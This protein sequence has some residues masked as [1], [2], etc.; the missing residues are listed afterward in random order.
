MNIVYLVDT[1]ESKKKIHKFLMT[2]KFR[3][4]P[5]YVIVIEHVWTHS[6]VGFTH[7]TYIYFR[8]NY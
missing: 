3:N 5:F 2:I 4:K 1:E 8:Q 7:Q 6:T